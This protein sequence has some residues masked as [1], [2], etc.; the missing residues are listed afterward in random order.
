MSSVSNNTPEPAPDE[1]SRATRMTI[2]RAPNLLAFLI[3]G[4]ILGAVGG[5]LFGLLGPESQYYTRGAIA[6]FFLVIGLVIG[7]GVGSVVSL[8]IDRVS[9]KRTRNVTAHI[10]DVHESG[11]RPG[12]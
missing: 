10:D 4:A 5:F 6:G 8:I 12:S 9:L 3:T 2:R 7:A 1:P 11:D